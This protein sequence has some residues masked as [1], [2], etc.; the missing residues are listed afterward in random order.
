MSFAIVLVVLAALAFGIG[1]LFTRLQAVAKK[2]RLD[3]ALSE[4]RRWVER[5][6][7][8]VMHLT[9]T[10]A[11][12]KQALADASERY[13]A[14]GSQLDLARTVG[15]AG[16]AKETALEGLYYIRAARVA[17]AL[18]PGPALPADAE[19]ARAGAVTEHRKVEVEGAT[20][21]ASPTPGHDTPHYYPGG[22]VAGRPVP[23]GWYNR[24]WWKPALIG[25]A[26]GAGAAV[27][28][29][30]L[31]AGMAGVAAAQT[32]QAGGQDVFAPDDVG[33]DDVGEF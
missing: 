31:F 13:T 9:G 16:L 25:G 29:G 7:G 19:R 3:E 24:P 15:Q 23:E 2:R 1:L 26:W 20:Y 12:A 14:A 17:M 8:Q 4:A 6:A 30:S 33:F 18:D 28:F 11:A 27:L 5:L 32:W 10:N 22:Q 21:E